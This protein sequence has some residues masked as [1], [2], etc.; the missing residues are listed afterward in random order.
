MGTERARFVHQIA[1]FRA[2]RIVTLFAFHYGFLFA[3]VLGEYTTLF[4]K[5]YLPQMQLPPNTGRETFS[6]SSWVE[7]TPFEFIIDENSDFTSLLLGTCLCSGRLP[8]WKR[9]KQVG[10]LVLTMYCSTASTLPSIKHST[11]SSTVT[12]S[13]SSVVGFGMDSMMLF[14]CSDF[15]AS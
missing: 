14:L 11:N 4:N 8:C 10:V 5:L 15:N 12:S 3:P 1:T 6:I 2:I 9:V 13:S 7:N